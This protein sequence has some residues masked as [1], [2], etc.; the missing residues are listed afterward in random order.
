MD[1]EYNLLGVVRVLIKWKNHIAIATVAATLIAAAYTLFFMED[2]YRSYATIYPI[3]LA[4][5]DRA[6]VFN[7]DHVEYYGNKE[8][9]NRILTIC[10]S[11]PIEGY[12]IEK[13]NLAAI[14]GWRVFRCEQSMLKS[15]EV[16]DHVRE[17]LGC[18]D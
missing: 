7:L 15:H 16:I 17:A 4:Y 12:I 2:Y 11:G 5:N 14:L 8:D 13:Y 10:Q 9:V 18:A 1:K 6:A 3:N